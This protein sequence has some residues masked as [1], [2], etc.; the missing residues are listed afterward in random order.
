MDRL[1]NIDE[2]IR[3]KLLHSGAHE[4]YKELYPNHLR[5][6]TAFYRLSSFV[7]YGNTK[8]DRIKLAECGFYN[9]ADTLQQ[10]AHYESPNTVMTNIECGAYKKEDKIKAQQF[11]FLRSV[12]GLSYPNVPLN[13]SLHNMAALSHGSNIVSTSVT[14]HYLGTMSEDKVFCLWSTELM[15][16][17]F[18]S[19]DLKRAKQ[20]EAKVVTKESLT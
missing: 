6:Y 14:G 20:P 13:V 18:I 8:F 3:C 17:K 11:P 4:L 1:L 2:Q 9:K 10:L 15:L 12:N 19:I 5:L 16:L 7:N